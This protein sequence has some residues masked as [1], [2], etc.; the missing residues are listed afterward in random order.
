MEIKQIRDLYVSEIIAE[1]GV[2]HRNIRH[3]DTED[4]SDFINRDTKQ[5]INQD[6]LM[7]TTRIKKHKGG[8]Y[9]NEEKLKDLW[10]VK[11]HQLKQAACN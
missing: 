7:L 11:Y 5:L 8:D 9:S 2:V 10:Y 6:L 1:E 4:L 3:R